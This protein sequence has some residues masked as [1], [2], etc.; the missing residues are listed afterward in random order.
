MRF[1]WNFFA[2]FSRYPRRRQA[3]LSPLAGRRKAPASA[4][5]IAHAWGS[6]LPVRCVASWN[7][8]FPSACKI[9]EI[10]RLPTKAPLI[11]HAFCRKRG[12]GCPRIDPD[13]TVDDHLV[14][15]IRLCRWGLIG[16]CS[17]NLV[18]DAYG[19][20]LMRWVSAALKILFADDP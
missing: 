3:F 20:N 17:R 5:Q 15:A 4:R 12:T 8:R 16:N 9:A 14:L 6:W 11:C 18:A 2:A 10:R 1:F 13:Q 19:N 7:V